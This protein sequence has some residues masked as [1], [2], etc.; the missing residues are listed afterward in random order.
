MAPIIQDLA[1]VV[2]TRSTLL[3]S[4][5]GIDRSPEHSHPVEPQ[6]ELLIAYG[7]F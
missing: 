6:Y 1:K 5:D 4:C 3:R 7:Q 2:G